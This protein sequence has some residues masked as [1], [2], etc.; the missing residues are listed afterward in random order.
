M[1]MPTLLS[2]LTL[3][4]G[5]ALATGLHA[6]TFNFDG[7]PAGTQANESSTSALRFEPAVFAPDLDADGL[8][9]P[10]TE[11]WRPDPAAPPVIVED[12][13]AYGR[14]PA[15]SP[16]NALN[17]L[18]Q[19]VLLKLAAPME[20]RAFSIT[21]DNDDLGL[22]GFEPAFADVAVH[23]L[24]ADGGVLLQLP[25]DQTQPGFS[26]V[27]GAPLAD[28]NCVLLPAGAFYDDLVLTPIPEIRAWP[29]LMGLGGLGFACWRRWRP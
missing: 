22:N 16:D 27:L 23:F 10:G 12:P 25:V 18:W 13:L 2:T 8:E 21:L 17:A 3:G 28:V 26:V 14:G 4:A 29:V 7:L 1:T 20:V 5:L 11:K 6:A 9:I 19:P 15:P 24:G